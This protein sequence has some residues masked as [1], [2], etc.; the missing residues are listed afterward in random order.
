M[1]KKN[2]ISHLHYF[3]SNKPWFFIFIILVFMIVLRIMILIKDKIIVPSLS[4]TYFP[5]FIFDEVKGNNWEV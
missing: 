5:S 1:D 4:Q 3:E 2:L